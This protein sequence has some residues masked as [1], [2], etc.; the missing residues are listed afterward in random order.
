MAAVMRLHDWNRTPLGAPE[1][2]PQPLKTLVGLLLAADQPMFICWGHD[3]LLL[4]NDAYAPMLAD[5]HPGAL[6]RPFFEVWS[7]VRDELTPLFD[8][9]WRG[10]A[11]HMDDITLQ[12]DRP[13]REPE[14]HFAFGYTPVRDEAGAV[15]G[16]F[17]ACTET[18]DQVLASRQSAKERN[19]L[20]N[21]T[22]DLFGV[23][24]FDGRLETI[25][26]AWSSV[27]SRSAEELLSRPFAE[28]IHPDDLGT[29]GAVVETLM[30]G[31]PVHQFQVR[32]LRA[33][34]SPISFA[35]SAVPDGHPG[36]P[37]LLHGGAGHH[38]RPAPRGNASPKSEDGGGRA[39]DGRPGARL[40]QPACGHLW[41]S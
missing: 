2:W 32:L 37:V 20:F 35:W 41:Q 40:Q 28:I 9:V 8:A 29:T 39:A 21:M 31:E 38:R 26:P 14:A 36:K 30:R 3:H 15:A 1:K 23:A 18:T 7:E 4:Y 25:N 24:T 5:R 19:R 6:G 12:L 17:C 27:L 10:E 22:R 11:V 34:G 33:D 16:L 13:G